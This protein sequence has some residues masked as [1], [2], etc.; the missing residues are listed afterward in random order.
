MVQLTMDVP[1][2]HHQERPYIEYGMLILD[3]K[4]EHKDDIQKL[5]MAS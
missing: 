1:Y 3:E 4:L 5:L 2:E